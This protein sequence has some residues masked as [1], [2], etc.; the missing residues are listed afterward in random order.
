MI[1]YGALLIPL[2]A[3]FILYKYF[4]RETVWWELLIPISISFI[5]IISAK[6][7][8]ETVQVSSKEYWGSFVTEAR[9]YEDWNEYIH[10]TCTR[11]CGKECTETYDCSYVEYHPAEYQ[12]ATTTGEILNIGR[13]DYHRL[14][15]LFGNENFKE[16]HRNYYTDDGDEYYSNW[17]GDSLKSFP[18]TTEHTYENRIKAADQSI[19]HFATVKEPEIKQYG[20]IQYPE[21]ASNYKMHVVLGD[22]SQD[23][24]NADKKVQYI[25]ALLGHKKQVKIFVLIFKNQPID[26]GLYQEWYWSGGNMNEF[27][28]CIGIDGARNVSWCKPVSWTQNEL[29]KSKVKD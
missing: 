4:S 25:N 19:F 12:I 20:L 3:A 18:V 21:I 16:L 11:S 9:Y 13:N 24:L 23:A 28:V 29:L 26:A 2:I 1:I 17:P 7:L 8:I 5:F 27:V 10:Q 6:S 22:S 14:V 15:T